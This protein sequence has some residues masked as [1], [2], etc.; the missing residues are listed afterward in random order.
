[1]TLLEPAVDLP[2][3]EVVKEYRDMADGEWHDL[4]RQGL[5]G[6]DAGKV[7]GW[8]KYGSPLTVVME[9]TGRLP[10]FEGNEAT[11]VGSALEPLIR[12]Y[13]LPEYLAK[14]GIVADVV[15]PTAL[16]RSTVEP[17]M[18]AN[19]DGFLSMGDVTVG[20]E[21]KTG[22]SYQLTNWGGMD[23]DEVPADYYAQVQHYMAVTGLQEWW[24]FGLIGNRRLLRKVKR[25]PAVI[26]ALTE[27]CEQ[28]W[29]VIQADDPARFPLP[30][31]LDA[32]DVAIGILTNP[33]E[34]VTVDLSE[35]HSEIARYVQIGKTITELEKE[36]KTLQQQIKGAMGTAKWG[37]T[38]FFEI[39][40][41]VYAK[42]SIDTKAIKEHHPDIAEKYSRESVV[43]FP[44][45]K[46]RKV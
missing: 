33:L 29:D 35:M 30:S 36:K 21:I 31:G 38:D 41:Q 34:E 20:L 27:A 23:G 13:M 1:M 25:D 39:T 32:E 7:L 3:C 44:R 2:G 24:V 40:R 45:I 46:E 18:L 6:S 16:Y 12:D 4:R 14:L 26:N 28:L 17:F 43:D 37:G 8:S 5:G 9:K 10:S 11:E 15:A 42:T 22:T 19:V